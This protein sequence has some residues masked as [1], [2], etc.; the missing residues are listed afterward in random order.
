MTPK[1]TTA[2]SLA[3]ATL[4]TGM[5]AFAPATR[6]G[7]LVAAAASLPEAT[8]PETEAD[9]LALTLPD[10]E[11]L[12][13]D[14]Q[15][16]LEAQA[17]RVRAGREQAIADGQLPDP[18]LM[19]GIR[20]LPV[21]GEDAFALGPDNFTMVTTSIRQEFPRGAKRRLMR[22][23]GDIE[24]DA[25]ALEFTAMQREVRR[26][27]AMA[28]LDIYYAEQASEPAQTL[29]EEY[30][31][32]LKA[33]EI[34]LMSNRAS[35]ADLL[36]ARVER[37][38]ARDRVRALSRDVERARAQLARWLG[39]EAAQRPLPPQL[40]NLPEPPALEQVLTAVRTHP[41]LS[42][43]SERVRVA[44]TEVALARQDYKPDWALSLDFGYRERFS[45]YIGLQ[46]EVDL[47]LFTGQRQNRRLAARLA[48]AEEMRGKQADVL[49]Q[50]E[51]QVRS[52]YAAWQAARERAHEFENDI[53]PQ[54]RHRVEAAQLAFES[55]GAFADLL[56]ARRARLETE[57]LQL[58]QLVEIARAQVQLRYFTE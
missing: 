17:A 11:A 28:W 58:E 41:H 45:D 12:A 1:M 5:L 54:A 8:V 57:L 30:D 13:L 51:A 37:D 9:R 10:A 44:E 43:I 39:A 53:L 50:Q 4:A 32:Q 33:L 55:R 15:P 27:A 26:E 31:A 24:A 29:V 46:F 19:T 49:R 40:P 21:N 48:S 56:L 36:A 3:V 38:L 42:S 16:L 14:R 25:D 35:Q 47:P 6:A 18:Q 23:R 7:T 52:A 20:D 2:A 34:A 22:E